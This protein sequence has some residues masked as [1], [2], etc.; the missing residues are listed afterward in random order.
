MVLTTEIE[1]T[2][3]TGTACIGAPLYPN[4]PLVPRANS[5]PSTCVCLGVPEEE[6]RGRSARRPEGGVGVVCGSAFS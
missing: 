6:R 4:P 5:L 2:A 1:V 3:Q